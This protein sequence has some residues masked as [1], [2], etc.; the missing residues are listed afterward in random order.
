MLESCLLWRRELIEQKP[1]G[2][3]TWACCWQCHDNPGCLLDEGRGHHDQVPPQP[4]ELGLS[5]PP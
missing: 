5:L 4:V 2:R 3:S 1:D